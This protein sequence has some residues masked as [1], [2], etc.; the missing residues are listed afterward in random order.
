MTK[1]TGGKQKRC[2]KILDVC[3]DETEVVEADAGGKG[4]PFW[5]RQVGLKEQ[6][7]FEW[8]RREALNGQT[9]LKLDSVPLQRLQFQ[10]LSCIFGAG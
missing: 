10:L 2:M 9:S 7:S 1:L 6:K 4:V 5:S 8:A 3:D